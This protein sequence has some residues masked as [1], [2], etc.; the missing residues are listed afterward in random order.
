M[1]M[2][3]T[4][5]LELNKMDTFIYKTE[6]SSKV[7]WI[8]I[9]LKITMSLLCNETLPG[10]T[11]HT[12]TRKL[13][14]KQIGIPLKMKPDEWMSFIGITHRMKGSLQEKTWLRQLHHQKPAP[15]WVTA[16]KPWE[17]GA[18][19][20]AYRCVNG[21]GS[22]PSKCLSCSKPLPGKSA[23]FYFFQEVGLVFSAV[24]LWS[25]KR[26]SQFSLFTL[27]GRV[28]DL[29]FGQFQE[30]PEALLGC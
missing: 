27:A 18:H 24:Y 22:V 11:Q 21:V 8:S 1:L 19:S 7:W 9:I 14:T 23:H 25:S 30:P 5:P 2:A 10:K 28:L 17:S 26:N 3:F 29:E 6:V 12:Q 4:L 15:V 13:L 16:H 20:T